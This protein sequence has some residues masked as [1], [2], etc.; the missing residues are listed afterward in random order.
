M[1]M[2]VMGHPGEA[3]EMNARAEANPWMVRSRQ[4]GHGLPENRVSALALCPGNVVFRLATSVVDA[5]WSE[6]GPSLPVAATPLSWQ[7]FWFRLLAVLVAVGLYGALV[8][9]YSHRKH[10]KRIEELE[11]ERRHQAE[12]VHAS[13][14]SLLGEFS[15]SLSHELK[16]PLAAILTNAQA[17]IRFLDGDPANLEEVRDSLKDI[18]EADRKAHEIIERMR[19]MMQKSGARMESGDLT[20]DIHRSLLLAHRDLVER[21]V[22]VITRLAPDLPPVIGDHLQLQQVLSNLIVNAGDAMVDC[23]PDERQ[24]T[25]ETRREGPEFIEVSVTDRGAGVAPEMLER[26]FEPFYST[27]KTG[28]GMGLSISRAMIRAHGGQLWASNLP[29]RGTVF[30]FTLPVKDQG[31]R[32]AKEMR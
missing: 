8:W 14:V 11:R 19:S 3:A 17:A 2:L 32:D 30:R 28:L 29:Q 24:L 9:W 18:M 26:I 12:L 23:P 5:G 27:K 21:G 25:I 16:Q 10:Q 31:F 6:P 1:G 7:S 15:A 13:R 22:S 20:V 4:V